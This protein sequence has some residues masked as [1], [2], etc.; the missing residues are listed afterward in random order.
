MILKKITT[1][2]VIQTFDTERGSFVEQEFVA[3]DDV[4]VENEHGDVVDAADRKEIDNIYLPFNMV[5]PSE[6]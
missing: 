1:G 3:G 4:T 5:Q 2:F 6:K